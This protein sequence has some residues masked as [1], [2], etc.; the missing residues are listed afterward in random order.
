MTRELPAR[1]DVVVVGGGV[2][3]ASAAFHLAEAGVADVLLLER[4]SLGGGSTVR[5]AGGVR[6]QFS[7]PV[8]IRLGARSL[9]A[10]EEFTTRP[11]AEIDLHQ[12]GY[13]FLHSEPEAWAAAQESVALQHD[14]G[15]PT[16]LLTAAAAGALHPGVVVDDVLGATYHSREG[17][18]SPENVVSGYADGARAHGATVRTGVAVTGIEVSGGSITGVRTSHG[19]V[20]TNAVVCAAGVWSREI[21][22]WTGVDLPVAPLRRQILVTEALPPHLAERFAG[23]VPMT[24]DAA[25]TLYL[26]REGPGLLIGMSYADEALGFHEGVSDAWLPALTSALE[27][28]AP[29]LLD[30][31]IAHRWAGYYEVT[32]DHNA[33][34]GESSAVSRFLYATGFSGHGFLQGPAVGEVLRDL[35]LGRDPV[36]DVASLDAERFAAGVHVRELNIV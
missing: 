8:N 5:S 19:L 24:I 9:S 1:A 3:G 22:G 2:M 6:A 7:D 20:E 12:V 23:D 33:L 34:I 32:P 28:R 21:G 13:L 17:H 11:G 29:D 36:V 10:F 35:F 14:L 18:C 26:H 25:T 4:D 30:V 27:H 31:G 15:V 16:R